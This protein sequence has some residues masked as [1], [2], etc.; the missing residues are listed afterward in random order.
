MMLKMAFRFIWIFGLIVAAASRASAQDIRLEIRDGLVTLSA[1]GAPV[2]QILKM[3]GVVGRTDIVN[4]ERV[5]GRIVSLELAGVPEEE[6]LGALLTSVGGYGLARRAAPDPNASIFERI[7]ILSPAPAMP[8]TAMPA[9]AEATDS[10]VNGPIV[11]PPVADPS[12][13]PNPDDSDPVPP[14]AESSSA[15]PSPP[16]S[17]S[18]VSPPAGNAAAYPCCDPPPPAENVDQSEP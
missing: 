16:E 6:A 10:L 14:A 2:S 12:T 8:I 17:G 5:F 18:S 9:A 7:L 4:I 13:G 11:D 1:Q 3:W 15:A